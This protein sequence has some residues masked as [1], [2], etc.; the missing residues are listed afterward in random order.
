MWCSAADTPHLKLLYLV[1]TVV[2]D[3]DFL[4]WGV[5]EC[6]IALRRSVAA[7]CMLNK[8]RCNPMHPPYGALPVQYNM[9]ECGLRLLL[10]IGHLYTNALQNLPVPQ[11]FYSPL[12]SS[13]FDGVG[14]GGFKISADL[15]SLHFCLLL[16][17][18][19]LLSFYWL[20][21][22]GSVFGL[23]WVNHSLPAAMHCRLLYILYI[24][25]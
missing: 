18:I 13:V 4:T 5:F 14:L 1:V 20:V 24:T 22:C 2:S 9:H 12:Y 8:I 7:L 23:L 25:Y 11:D 6:D 21:L 17:Y 3:A 15:C 16:F 10:L 19:S